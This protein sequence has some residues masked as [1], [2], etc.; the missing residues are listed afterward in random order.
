MRGPGRERRQARKSDVSRVPSPP[1]GPAADSLL[2]AVRRRL[3]RIRR[4][5]QLP[6]PSAA[7][8]LV[9]SWLQYESGADM[10]MD[11]DPKYAGLYRELAKHPALEAIQDPSSVLGDEVRYPLETGEVV[12]L[13]TAGAVEIDEAGSKVRRLADALDV[14]RLG[15]SGRRVFFAR[16]VARVAYMLLSDFTEGQAEALVRHVRGNFTDE[17]RVLVPTLS[18][19]TGDAS[20]VT[21]T[22]RIA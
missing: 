11:R 4:G 8:R 5:E 10:E 20:V 9:L 15:K 12:K 6:S 3:T 1:T 16:D 17:E 7:E 13:L 21:R 18:P 2:L 19:T 14:P 22:R